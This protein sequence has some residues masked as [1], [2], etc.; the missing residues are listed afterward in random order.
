MQ[1]T[2]K[3]YVSDQSIFQSVG[4]GIVE[5][6]REAGQVATESVVDLVYRWGV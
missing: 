2:L 1:R 4:S 3:G 6:P 5:Q